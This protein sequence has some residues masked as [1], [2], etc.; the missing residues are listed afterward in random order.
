MLSFARLI[1]LPRR[2]VSCFGL[3]VVATTGCSDLIRRRTAQ[4]ETIS[5]GDVAQSQPVVHSHAFTMRNVDATRQ[6]AAGIYGVENGEWR[7]TAGEFSIVLATPRGASTR[8]ADLVFEFFI[9]DGNLHR[10]GPVTLT[11]YLNEVE[12]GATTYT[13][14][15]AQRFSA[16]APPELIRQSPVVID[17]HL[18]RN[19][20]SGVLET[21]ELGVVALAVS[22]R[23]E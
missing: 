22:L 10:T 2:W 18:D 21:R 20:P 9:P 4:P 5:N 6:L 1:G 7:W 23:R 14:P 19:V 15:G 12:I 16:M 8:G 17:F 3:L 13:T 11:A